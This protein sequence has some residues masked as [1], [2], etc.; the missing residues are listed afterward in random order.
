[1]TLE[2]REEG[3]VLREELLDLG[4]TCTGPIL[5]PRLGEVVLD[6]V[7]A[8]FAHAGHDRP[9]VGRSPWADRLN[10]R[11]LRTQRHN[12]VVPRSSATA[13]ELNRVELLAG[14]PGQTLAV[15][16]K[17]ME[18]EEVAPGTVIVREGEPGDRFYVVFAG[19]LSVTQASFPGR[20][21]LRPGD[22]FGEVA[23]AR[24]VPR[25]ATVIAITPAVVA[26]C[27]RETFDELIRPIFA[28]D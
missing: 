10:F 19:M 13:H 11:Y 27:D 9:P 3:C 16:A 22:Y 17:R 2:E 28:E 26:S 20:K 24:D 15:L 7:E 25:T 14:L 23:L 4:D 6:S 8:A 5:E 18:R 12:Q 1:V 21:L